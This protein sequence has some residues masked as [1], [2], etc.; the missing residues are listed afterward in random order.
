MTP[1]NRREMLAGLLGLGGLALPRP[2]R[3]AAAEKPWHIF[4]VVW[5]GEESA[6][7]GFQHYFR[8]R[9][10]PVEFTVRDCARDAGRLPG[11]VDEIKAARPDLV[12]TW[13]T[14]VTLNVLGRH[15]AVDPARHVT[16]IP[17][18]FMIVSQPVGAGIVPSFDGSGRNVAGT[19]YLV[20]EKVQVQAARR[21]F[22]FN[23]LG[24]I[25]NPNE[26]NARVS[27]QRLKDLQAEMDLTVLAKPVPLDA[28]DKPRPEALPGLV[29]DLA[30]AGADLLYQPPDS[31][32]MTRKERLTGAAL[33]HGLPTLAAGEGP[34]RDAHALMGVVNRY[35]VVGQL[36]AQKAHKILLG[37]G[38]PATMP[39]Q[40][41][42]EFA[43]VINMA[44]ARRLALYPPMALL[45]M[46]EVVKE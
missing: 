22:D 1:I 41:P 21:Y 4:M 18:V 28:D 16:D 7:R 3:A 35:R 11:F 32:L 27:V 33:E 40:A 43:I 29:A 42:P 6:T 15:D 26:A 19:R 10:L 9:D 25:Y 36:T 46:A 5:R 37:E 12:V 34:V 17:A 24:V 30:A 20:R 31:F 44:A 2:A 14:T 13:G 8:R 45:R 39:I 38:D 23:T